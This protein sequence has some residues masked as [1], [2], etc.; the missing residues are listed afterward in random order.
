MTTTAIHGDVTV[1]VAGSVAEELLER[2]GLAQGEAGQG[3]RLRDGHS[4]SDPCAALADALVAIAEDDCAA[5][6]IEDEEPDFQAH[7]HVTV[8]GDAPASLDQYRGRVGEVRGTELIATPAGEVPCA[9][10]HFGH[11]VEVVIAHE[12]LATV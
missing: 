10:V 1:T 9:R 8:E 5:D 3:W 11:G 2:A 4:T 6:C 12:Y 7:S